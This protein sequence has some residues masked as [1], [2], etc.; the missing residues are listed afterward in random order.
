MNISFRNL[1]VRPE[2]YSCVSFGTKVHILS[3]RPVMDCVGFTIFTAL[4]LKCNMLDMT[5]HIRIYADQRLGV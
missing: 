3:S 5:L 1:G 2:A 4:I